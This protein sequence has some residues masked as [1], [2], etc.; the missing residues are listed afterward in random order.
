MLGAALIRAM[1]KYYFDLLDGHTECDMVG[2]DLADDGAA[3]QEGKLR[4]LNGSAH[5][6]EHYTGAIQIAVRNEAGQI[7]LKT[8]I[9][10][11]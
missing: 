9:K 3:C 6:L 4:A 2:A 8:K 11:R 1:P 7:I 10:R 5:Q